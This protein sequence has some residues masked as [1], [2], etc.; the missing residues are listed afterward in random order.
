MTGELL[1]LLGFRLSKMPDY[2]GRGYAALK[3]E[4]VGTPEILCRR[5]ILCDILRDRAEIRRRRVG[6]AREVAL[7]LPKPAWDA[8][9]ALARAA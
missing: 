1:T 2:Y 5:D 7:P 4:Y 8:G 6:G 3:P 9:G